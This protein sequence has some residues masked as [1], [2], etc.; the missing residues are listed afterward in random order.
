M[1]AL[2][3]TMGALHE[4]HLA[5]M[6]EA[7][8]CVGPKGRVVVSIF[9]NPAQFAPHEDFNR[10]PRDF[11][12]DAAKLESTKAA[13]LIYAPDVDEMYPNGFATTLNVEGPATGLESDAR[14]H[15]FSGV[16]IVVAKL[17]LQCRP[18]IACFG[19]KDYQQL[20][21]VKRLARDLDLGI[22]VVGVPIVREQD[23]LALSSRNAFLSPA[24]RKIA[25]SLNAILASTG[26]GIRNGVQIQRAEQ[27]AASL[28][29]QS[30]FSRV[31]YVAVRDVET[32][33]HVTT[34]ERPA[35]ILAAAVVGKTRLI[36]N[37]VV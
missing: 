8:A 22:D 10:Y 11:D 3:P 35:R 1:L 24:E 36:D 34:L 4:G 5:L 30:G 27:E 25:G 21:V 28:L 18:D 37:M 16:A 7:R 26:A 13:D 17:F 20:L 12:G 23:G 19:E 14:P 6:R 29:K 33:E 2:V 31:D 9:V 15:F 32:L